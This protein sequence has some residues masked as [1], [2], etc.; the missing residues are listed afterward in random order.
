[1][2]RADTPSWQ[3]TF[4]AAGAGLVAALGRAPGRVAVVTGAARGEGRTTA[5][6]GLARALAETGMR[7]VAVDLDLRRPDL[8][9]GLGAANPVGAA[10]VLGRLKALPECLQA[11]TTVAEGPAD[12]GSGVR[13][14]AAGN[15]PAD[16]GRLLSDGALAPMLAELASDAD[17]VLVDTPPLLAFA[18]GRLIGAHTDGAVVVV[19]ERRTRATALDEVAAAL[20]LSGIPALGVLYNRERR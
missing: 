14:L 6:A 8:H 20:K 12:G 2:A 4:R 18:D 5:C 11:V 15:P 17:L 19:Q 3:E 1:M 10:E 9:R 13:L 7:V 16:P